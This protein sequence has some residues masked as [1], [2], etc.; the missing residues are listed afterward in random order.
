M[1]QSN[2]A[3]GYLVSVTQGKPTEEHPEAEVQHI[4]HG[5]VRQGLKPMARQNIHFFA[6]RSGCAGMV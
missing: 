2:T 4:V 3:W 1:T 5:I 6:H